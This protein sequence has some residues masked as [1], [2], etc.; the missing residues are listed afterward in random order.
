[1]FNKEHVSTGLCIEDAFVD[2]FYRPAAFYK[3]QRFVVQISI[4]IRI[5]VD[6]LL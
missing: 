5:F 2:R 3:L 1:M 4:I 6:A